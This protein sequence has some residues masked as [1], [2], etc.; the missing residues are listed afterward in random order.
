MR[1][2]YYKQENLWSCGAAAMKMALGALGIKRSEAQLRRLLH[3]NQRFGT[4]NRAFP[5]LAERLRLS[6]RVARRARI[7]DIKN[8]LR[9]GFVVIVGFTYP[10]D[11]EGHFAVVRSV[12]RGKIRLLDPS[13]G[14]NTSYPHTKFQKIWK[15]FFG[16]DQRDQRWFIALKP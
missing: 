1:I 10:E 9:Q 13:A 16:Q 6:Y 12:E 3:T 4:P 2:P 14:P 7:Q 5:A 15:S 8:M 11:K